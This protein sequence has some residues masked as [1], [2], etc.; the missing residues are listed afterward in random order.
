MPALRVLVEV[1]AAALYDTAPLPAPVA[2]E[3]MVI[4][5]A[6]VLAVQAQPCAVTIWINPL[7]VPPAGAVWVVLDWMR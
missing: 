5:E 3:L 7:E 1:L 6:A 2:P 4:Q